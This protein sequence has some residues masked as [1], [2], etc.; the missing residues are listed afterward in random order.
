MGS[1]FSVPSGG[2][3]GGAGAHEE[4]GH[5]RRWGFCDDTVRALGAAAASGLRAG[6]GVGAKGRRRGVVGEKMEDAAPAAAAIVLAAGP[7]GIRG[8]WW[9]PATEGDKPS[10]CYPLRARQGETEVRALSCWLLERGS[11]VLNR[12]FSWPFLRVR[13]EFPNSFRYDVRPG[14][15]KIFNVVKKKRCS[16]M[17]NT[18]VV[19]VHLPKDVD[20]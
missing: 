2:D 11:P 5:G 9:R 17:C 20:S 16:T 18:C 3:G 13:I 7:G 14:G 15:E 19:C 6:A 10:V 8:D 4:G 12:F 1:G